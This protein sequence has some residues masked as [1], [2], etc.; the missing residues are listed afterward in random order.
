MTKGSPRRSEAWSSI[1]IRACHPLL[2]A[3]GVSQ[4]EDF[5]RQAG[6]DVEEVR[7]RE[8]IIRVADSARKNHQDFLD[9]FKAGSHEVEEIF[10]M[11]A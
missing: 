4:V 8:E 9:D 6:G 7:L 3:E 1:P 11:Q 5:L 2:D 10:P